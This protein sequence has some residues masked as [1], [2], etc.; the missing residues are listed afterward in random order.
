MKLSTLALTS[1]FIVLSGPSYAADMS[2]TADW[3]TTHRVFDVT[4]EGGRND[5]R[6]EVMEKAL[7]KAAKSTLKKDFEW[8]RV[9]ERDTDKEIHTTRSRGSAT[10]GFSRV[11]E[12]HCGLLGCSTNYRTHYRGGFDTTTDERV[13]ARYSVT[14]EYQMGI[15]PVKKTDDVYNAKIVKN[16]Y[17]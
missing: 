15:G 14:L 8:F 16:A 9:V 6:S 3:N 4:V 11:P 12:R 17:K 10:P 5:S 7:Y 13:D 2:D 1:M